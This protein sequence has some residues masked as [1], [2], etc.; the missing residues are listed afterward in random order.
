MALLHLAEPSCVAEN[1]QLF[2]GQPQL[3][4]PAFQ[5]CPSFASFPLNNFGPPPGLAE[6]AECPWPSKG[7]SQRDNRSD[8]TLLEESFVGEIPAFT[9]M[10][11][12]LTDESVM[13]SLA[14]ST[15]HQESCE[16]QLTLGSLPQFTMGSL[17][18]LTIGSLPSYAA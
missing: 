12:Q 3:E 7:A 10:R 15:S 9:G 6:V 14:L 4:V 17:P 8:H 5:S 11:R 18:Q 16:S 1:N 13:S 2:S